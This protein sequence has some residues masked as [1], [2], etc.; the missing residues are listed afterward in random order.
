MR[1]LSLF[2]GNLIHT[3]VVPENSRPGLLKKHG[4]SNTIGL[5]LIVFGFVFGSLTAR[6]E[7]DLK[8]QVKI[9]NKHKSIKDMSASLK[10]VFK[11]PADHR[12]IDKAAR[13][14][15]K[16]ATGSK[17]WYEVKGKEIAFMVNGRVLFT[18]RPVNVNKGEFLFNGHKFVLNSKLSYKRHKARMSKILRR[19]AAGLEQFFYRQSPCWLVFCKRRKG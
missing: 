19:Q 2:S 7:V 8:E 18:F 17:W 10:R 4:F 15:S 3:P 14:I 16:M 6:A 13:R 9:L 12:E 5:S 11:R 1:L